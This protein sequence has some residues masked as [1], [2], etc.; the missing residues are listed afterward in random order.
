M[1]LRTATTQLLHQRTSY[2]ALENPNLT[3]SNN[4]KL[5]AGINKISLLSIVVGILNVDVHYATWN[6]AVLGP[7]TLEGHNERT[8]DLTNQIWSNEGRPGKLGWPSIFNI[9][10]NAIMFEKF[11]VCI[12]AF[13]AAESNE[14]VQLKC[15]FKTDLLTIGPQFGEAIDDA[16]RYF[17]EAYDKG[18]SP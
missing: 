1:A 5:K 10:I 11:L 2:G 4:V 7:V 8:T 15:L 13:D 16:A 17:N 18:L 3:F 6:T 9:H 12:V 14:T